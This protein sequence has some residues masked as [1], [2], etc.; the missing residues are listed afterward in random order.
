MD[1]EKNFSSQSESDKNVVKLISDSKLLDLT[2]KN[3]ILE[4]EIGIL[5]REGQEFRALA[6]ERLV[7]CEDLKVELVG[8]LLKHSDEIKGLRN[9]FEGH[10]Q[11]HYDIEEV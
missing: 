3:E 5:G 1:S 7:K 11:N 2:I 9:R 4:G 8:V 10:V 6:R